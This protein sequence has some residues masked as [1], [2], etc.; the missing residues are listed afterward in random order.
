[1]TRQI[2]YG[3]VL[4]YD[5]AMECWS[6]LPICSAKDIRIYE[7]ARFNKLKYQDLKIG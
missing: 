6:I 5:D 1:M 3:W 4:Q 2:F 7:T